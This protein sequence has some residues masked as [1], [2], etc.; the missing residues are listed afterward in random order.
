MQ[1]PPSQHGSLQAHVPNATTAALSPR[2]PAS[3]LVNLTQSE[4]PKI[5]SHG[6]VPRGKVLKAFTLNVYL[7][8]KW[9]RNKCL[10]YVDQAVAQFCLQPL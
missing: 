3:Q 5:I 6:H 7:L 10:L 4:P 8:G 9:Q 2:P 1:L